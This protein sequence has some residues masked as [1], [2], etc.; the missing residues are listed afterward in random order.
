MIKFVMVKKKKKTKKLK[1]DHLKQ[2]TRISFFFMLF[3][4]QTIFQNIQ[5]FFFLLL[6]GLCNLQLN[7]LHRIE[8][9]GFMYFTVDT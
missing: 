2:L 4:I 6:S 9:L 5:E 1:R 7:C 3:A 8:L